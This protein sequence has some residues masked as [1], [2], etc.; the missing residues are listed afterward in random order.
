LPSVPVAGGL[1]LGQTGV[2]DRHCRAGFA[3]VK[4]NL[5]QA[6]ARWQ[7]VGT[8][9]PPTDEQPVGRVDC[10]VAATDGNAAD[11]NAEFAAGMWIEYGVFAH[12]ERQRV[13]ASEVLEDTLR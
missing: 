5:E 6:G 7:M 11:V 12:P 2:V 4:P 1:W 10:E 9:V 8:C 13:G 3:R